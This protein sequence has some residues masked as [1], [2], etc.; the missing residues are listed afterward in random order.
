VSEHRVP[1]PE[2]RREIVRFTRSEL[3][4]HWVLLISLTGLALTGLAL[5]AHATWFGRA[6]I[7][8]EGGIESRGNLH[9]IFAVALMALV[10]WHFVYVVFSERGH[11]QLMAM[12]IH[13]GDFRD[14]WAL[15][16]YYVG[17]RPEP[18]DFGRFTPM[19]KLQYWGAGVGSLTMVATGLVLWF[20]TAAMAV[21][22]K[23]VFDLTAIVHGYEGLILF[24]LLF[25]WHLYI[26]HLSPGNFPI[27][28]TFL[29]G[30]ITL[31]REWREH[32]VEYRERI[33]DQP[34]GA[35]RPP[36][37]PETD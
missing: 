4:Q 27:Q 3:A 9:R 26:V 33:G 28:N 20:H 2:G 24:A 19:Q 7:T 31:D 8:L 32:R 30:R 11:R 34:P 37:T 23:W 18:P 36:E 12:K 16:G 10:V 6:L 14:F 15:L 29:H 5:F 22:P 13:A 17:R 21:M 35:D 25:G 1:P